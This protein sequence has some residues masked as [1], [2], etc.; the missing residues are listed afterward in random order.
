MAYAKNG[1]SNMSCMVLTLLIRGKSLFKN[2]FLTNFSGFVLIFLETIHACASYLKIGFQNEFVT[3]D[4]VLL[5]KISY[6]YPCDKVLR[7]WYK[8][9]ITCYKFF[10]A[11]KASAEYFLFRFKIQHILV[12]N[13]QQCKPIY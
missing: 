11:V 7:I 13:Y 4:I 6:A 3:V 9:L 2:H 12:I 5:W 1:S 10:W 8:V